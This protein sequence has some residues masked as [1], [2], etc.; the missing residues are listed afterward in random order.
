[1]RQRLT[2]KRITDALRESKGMISV[3]ARRI[4]CSRTTIYAWAEEHPEIK[5]T[6]EDERELMTDLTELSLYK[7]V[8]AGE[9]W[10]VQFYLRTQGK[11]RG[12]G[13]E[14]RHKIGGDPD[15]PTP[16]TSQSSVTLYIPDNGRG[17]A[18]GDDATEDDAADAQ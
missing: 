8:Q 13:D 11:K 10:A 5:A 15:N 16:I 2:V 14:M 6:L 9:G 3:A 12:Y 17:A 4:G 18:D 1:M 7:Q